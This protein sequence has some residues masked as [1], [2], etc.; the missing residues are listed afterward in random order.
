MKIFFE[1]NG[2]G[3]EEKKKDSKVSL[4]S[5]A[6]LFNLIKKKGY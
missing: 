2:I 5:E 3:L 1:G 6:Y 4:F